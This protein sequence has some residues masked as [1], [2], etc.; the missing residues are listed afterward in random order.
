METGGAWG[1]DSKLAVQPRLEEG[2]EVARGLT[3][4]VHWERFAGKPPAGG[5]AVA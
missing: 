2:R 1:F 4:T 5:V 3:P